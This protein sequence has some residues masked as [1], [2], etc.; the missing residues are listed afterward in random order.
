M[1]ISIGP[2]IRASFDA[3]I[4]LIESYQVNIPSESDEDAKISIFQDLVKRIIVSLYFLNIKIAVSNNMIPA[5]VM[6]TAESIIE[7]K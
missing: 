2:A 4:L 3:P 6:L 7:E 1:I 5:N